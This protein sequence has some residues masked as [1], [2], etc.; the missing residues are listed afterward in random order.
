LEAET[1]E[2]GFKVGDETVDRCQNR[3]DGSHGGKQLS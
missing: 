2:A 3:G 1:V